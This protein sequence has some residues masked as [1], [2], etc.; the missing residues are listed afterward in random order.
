VLN[1]YNILRSEPA[2]AAIPSHIRKQAPSILF[3]QDELPPKGVVVVVVVSKLGQHHRIGF[4][5]IC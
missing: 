1:A 3:G 4:L 2:I 5:L